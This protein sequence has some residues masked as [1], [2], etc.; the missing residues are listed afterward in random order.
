ML[1]E[2][3][4][5]LLEFRGRIGPTSVNDA[6]LH[7]VVGEYQDHQHAIRSKRHEI[8]V[9]QGK[10]VAA[11]HR[12]QT[13]KVGH[14]RQQLGD[15]ADQSLRTQLWRQALAELGHLRV[16]QW[17]DLQHAVDEKAI[18]LRCRHTPGRGVR[19]RNQTDLLEIGHD[20]ADRGRRDV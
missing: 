16:I 8:D 6:V 13:Y 17:L 12:H 4:G 19:G 9:A 3:V 2:I 14:R 7:L 10:L 15:L 5:G 18:S 11:R 20:V 1:V